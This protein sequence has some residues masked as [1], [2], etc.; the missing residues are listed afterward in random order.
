MSRVV[1]KTFNMTLS[2]I[3]SARP[4]TQRVLIEVS[5]NGDIHISSTI[6]AD[7][8]VKLLDQAMEGI[9]GQRLPPAD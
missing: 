3:H 8:T 1:T 6:G 7:N 5:P 9:D 2:Q 4:A